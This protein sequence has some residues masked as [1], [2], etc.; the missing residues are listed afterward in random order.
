MSSSHRRALR[1]EPRGVTAGAP[2]DGAWHDLSAIVPK[3]PNRAPGDDEDT[4][5]S[6]SDTTEAAS[7]DDDGEG[8]QRD[9][10]WVPRARALSN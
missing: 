4:E 10:W 5:Q 3:A 2:A 8:G 1:A 7:D 9:S 6:D